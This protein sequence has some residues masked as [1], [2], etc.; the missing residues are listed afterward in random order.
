M[1]NL[2]EL[3]IIIIIIIIISPNLIIIIIMSPTITNIF[4]SYSNDYNLRR[5]TD[6]LNE[7]FP[8]RT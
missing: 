4:F 2:S 8:G 5:N 3:I 7:G 1:K 6:R